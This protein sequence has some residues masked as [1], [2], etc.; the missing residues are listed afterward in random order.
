MTKRA[1]KSPEQADAEFL[2]DYKADEWPG[3]ALAVDVVT[4]GVVAGKLCVSLV[5]RTELPQKG[6]LAL[7]GGFVRG[8]ESLDE[9]VSRVLEQKAG[10]RNVYAEQMYTFGDAGRDPRT[11]VVSVAY[12]ALAK[13]LMAQ[14]GVVYGEIRAPWSGEV[15]GAVLVV[16][17]GKEEKLTFD[18][19]EIIGV[20]LKRLRGKLRYTP[21]AYELLGTEF[22]LRALQEVHEAI[23]GRSVDKNS[24]RRSSLASGDL[25]STGSI[26]ENVAWRPAELYSWVGDRA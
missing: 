21:V 20:A 23:L 4:L 5:R 10:A 26:E 13:D 24:F 19:A 8:P 22:T 3:V 2:A 18:H 25:V 15:G 12:L 9:A 1:E 11:R 6:R 17:D 14:T 16:V 7:P